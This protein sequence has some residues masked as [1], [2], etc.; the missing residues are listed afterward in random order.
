MRHNFICYP[1]VD[2]GSVNN[3]MALCKN[4]LDFLKVFVIG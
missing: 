2:T 3:G 4:C 1:T